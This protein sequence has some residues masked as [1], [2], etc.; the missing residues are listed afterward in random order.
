MSYAWDRNLDG[1][2]DEQQPR[3]N[4]TG[5]RNP[6]AFVVSLLE[7][8]GAPAWA[9]VTNGK[10]WRLYAARAH[11]RATNY[12]EI[13]LEET[14]ASREPDLAFRYF[15]L[16]FRARAFAADPR[17]NGRSF[18]DEIFD[19]SAQFAKELGERLKER[20]FEQIFPYFAE[21]F[22]QAIRAREGS[23][24]DLSPARR[25]LVFRG[26]LTFLY[27]LLFLLYSESRDLLPLRSARDYQ[28]VSLTQL[29]EEI[30]RKAGTIL[31][32][33]PAKL[34][35]AYS[36]KETAL[37]ERLSALFAIVDGGD[38][39][40]NVPLYNGGLFLT[41]PGADDHSPEAESARFLAE[42]KIP[43][44]FL[45]LGLDRM[46]RDL[47][48]KRGDLVF[49]DYKSLGVRQFGSIYE[50]LL[51]FTI[52]IA[53]QRMAVV[54]GKKT[55]EIVPY[56][57]AQAGKRSILKR[58]RGRT[59]PEWVLEPG[60]VYLENDK[61]ERKA[62]GSYY[63]PDYIVQYIV[64]QTV[65]PV[66]AAKCEALLPRIR[67]AQQRFR[68][69]VQRKRVVEKVAPN[70]PALL[71]EIAGAVL[72]E[73]FSLR[74]CDPAMGS[75][76][77]L[78]E[79]V[80]YITDYLVRFMERFPFLSHFFAGMRRSIL[81]GM[82]AQGVII[83]PARLSDVNLLKRHVLKRCV[84]GVDKNPM[85]VELAKVSLWLDC[86][87]LGAPLSFLDHHLKCGNSLI[88]I[89]DVEKYITPGSAR[90]GEFMQALAN[91][92]TIAELTDNTSAEVAQSQEL[93]RQV[94]AVIQP[95]REQLNVDLAASFLDLGS[96][97]H[98]RRVAYIAVPDRAAAVD[99][100]TLEKFQHAQAEAQAR[101][102][103]HWKLEFP[104]VFVD[105]QQRDWQTD[106]GGFDVIVGN[107]PYVATTD[108]RKT[109]KQEWNFYKTGYISA[110]TGKFDIYLPFFEQAFRLISVQNG[111]AA[112]ILPNKWIKSDA[113]K[114]LRR[115]FALNRA[116]ES[117]VDFGA[118]QVFQE[119]SNSSG[120]TTYTCVATLSKSNKKT[121]KYALVAELH[122][123][124]SNLTWSETEYRKLDEEPWNIEQ[125]IW[126]KGFGERF[127]PLGEAAT[128]FVGTTTNADPVFIFE[129][130]EDVGDNILVYSE[131][132]QGVIEIERIVCLPFLRGKDIG[133]FEIVNHNVL[134]LFPYE[135]KDGSTTLIDKKTMEAR[136]PLAWKYLLR[137]RLKLEDRENGK[138][139]NKV[140]WYCHAYPRNHGYI[141]EPKILTPDLSLGGQFA[142]DE[143]GRFHLLN[144]VYGVTK[145][146]SFIE[147]TFLLGVL[148]STVFENY[149]RTNSVDLRGGYYR[150]TKNFMEPFPLRRIHFTTPAAERAARAGELV[151]LY[152]QGADEELLAAV[153]RC[154]PRDG[155]GN[156]VAFAA[157]ATGRE[158]QSDVVHDLLAHLAERMIGLNEQKQ[159]EQR[160][161]LGWLEQEL[162]IGADR[163][164]NTGLD[165]LTGKSRLRGYLGDYQKGEDA[166]SFAELEEI[167]FKNKARLGVALSAAFSTHL[168]AEYERSL[169]T[170]RPLKEALARTDA[171][172]D[173]VVY[174]LYG[175]SAEEI[176]VVE[177][178]RPM[179]SES[180]TARRSS[181]DGP[182][183][184]ARE[185]DPRVLAEI[186]EELK[187]QGPTT[188][189]QLSDALRT[190]IGA[191]LNELDEEDE[192]GTRLNPDHAE[193]IR[194]EFEFLG[195]IEPGQSRWTLT[196]VGQKLARQHPTERPTEFALELCIANDRLNQRV[197]SRLLAR[198]W[199][200]NPQAQGA[201]IIPQPPVEQAPEQLEALRAWL[202]PLLPRWI[203]A[204]GRQMSGFRTQRPASE[205]V[206]AIVEGLGSRWETLS[207]RE[208]QERLL[209]VI[210][211][212]FM[213]LMFGQIVSPADVKIWRWRMGWAG[214]THS[215]ADLLGVAGQVWF[216]V[217]AFRA[218]AG[219]DFRPIEAL[220]VNGQ[221]Y[222]L[223]VP[224]GS[225]F[226]QR[227]ADTLF[228]AY[229]QRQQLERVEFVSLPA[230]RDNVC[231]RL[232][233][234]NAIFT[235]TL[236]ALFP[237]AVR[238][239][240]PYAL[241][242]EVDVTPLERRQLQSR[243][244]IV[245]DGI[246]RYIIAMRRR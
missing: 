110:Q 180:S 176:A 22:I 28:A 175:L 49:I 54:R 189:K 35:K 80:D 207:P 227:F 25:E 109:D 36:P 235:A 171:L 126:N 39:A 21:G 29:K 81:A 34:E 61:R 229:Q 118:N 98:A 194:R 160:R 144:T 215:T 70:E 51:E 5:E 9:I 221:A 240:T 172:I 58:G 52:Q 38:P 146:I 14:I 1:R 77:F 68:D 206:D 85:A 125:G 78:V 183:S 23:Q 236:Q 18:L 231:F 154:L 166:L 88:G 86:F 6:G 15:W 16:F 246:P 48:P 197:V 178:G 219:A 116:V 193:T 179:R 117:V 138:W 202:R 237:Q 232:R 133:R 104:E 157:G 99:A 148:N 119:E 115:N 73:L 113:G 155:A 83:D 82:E 42:H 120:P 40:R 27:R 13:D 242:L 244:P 45:A 143:S 145:P 168:R 161:F 64:R 198:L 90:W 213:D 196:E 71:N 216:P 100:V 8:P 139:K 4:E 67:Q 30:A 200:L 123:G 173:Q 101:R 214:L 134:V 184:I 11:S 87:T 199:E 66:L 186:L 162:R 12:Y 158:E 127:I 130:V 220:S 224:G 209:V 96:T 201:V 153:E 57:E 69:T 10:L 156:F 208:R 97:A 124:I 188:T 203:E 92:V 243:L 31:D 37:Y 187:R 217:G 60:T 182:R 59:A 108:L 164:G 102:F 111:R 7:Q 95:Q 128:I 159:A 165:A 26:T 91:I 62:T 46:A 225:A 55:E 167:L 32:E 192:S 233:I 177:G 94:Q 41:R 212:R 174:R 112:F 218:Q 163:A 151:G 20:V 129:R 170:L 234:S 181:G 107:P 141:S 44:R 205:L 33:V 228:E 114:A 152:E 195:W 223:Y 89:W 72:N 17:L 140:D 147:L 150:V 56:V 190:R 136:Y 53:E 103:F 135:M 2:E 105:H 63:T 238:N 43:D 210:A 204:L 142:L 121:L 3:D 149:I 132:E 230:V 185:S 131:E 74:V 75:G 76:H 106:G 222:H 24:A 19:G 239:E 65:G 122:D 137:H 245:I 191:R 47:D 241:A 226:E 169:A 93:Y 79:A 50:G 84:Y 211:E